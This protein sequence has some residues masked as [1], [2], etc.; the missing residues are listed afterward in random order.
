MVLLNNGRYVNQLDQG[1]FQSVV[2]NGYFG[3]RLGQVQAATSNASNLDRYI[4]P[5]WQLING[6]GFGLNYLQCTV[7]K[8]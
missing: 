8:M 6:Y 7:T 5:L 4:K 2:D 1:Q 3:S